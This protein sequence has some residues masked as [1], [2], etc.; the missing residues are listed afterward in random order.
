MHN[1]YYEYAKRL[2]THP[3]HNK[4]KV[5]YTTPMKPSR[6]SACAHVVLMGATGCA[7]GG[8]VRS[9][10]CRALACWASRAA[11]CMP[12]EGLATGSCRRCD[13]LAQG[14]A[15][16]GA[17]EQHQP[18]DRPLHLVGSLAGRGH[19]DERSGARLRKLE[20][21]FI[22]LPRFNEVLLA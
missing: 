12:T 11:S 16:Q 3:F 9:S 22:K 21:G 15:G 2:H 8:L 4:K 5:R 7:H 20:P 14:E 18:S 19:E 1:W 17:G 10:R 6:R 13:G